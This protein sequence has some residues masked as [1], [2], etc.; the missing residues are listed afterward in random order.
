MH[1]EMQVTGEGLKVIRPDEAVYR[2]VL[3]TLNEFS[4]MAFCQSVDG[5][6]R[7]PKKGVPSCDKLREDARNLRSGDPR[8]GHP[9]TSVLIR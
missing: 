4:G 1:P 3:W 6:V 2:C 5:S 8:M 7:V 9:S